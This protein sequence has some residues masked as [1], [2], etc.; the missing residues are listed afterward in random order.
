ML[1]FFKALLY[2]RLAL[3]PALRSSLLPVPTTTTAHYCSHCCN[4]YLLYS[5]S[6]LYY[7]YNLL[8]SKKFLPLTAHMKR[9]SLATSTATAPTAK[10]SSAPPSP[11]P[12]SSLE[13]CFYGILKAKECCKSALY[14]SSQQ[15]ALF[16][17]MTFT[18]SHI[19]V[20]LIVLAERFICK[21]RGAHFP[22]YQS[23]ITIF[24][25]LLVVKPSETTFY[26]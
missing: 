6:L 17:S 13:L 2:S 21:N 10:P 20:F 7:Y 3:L 14:S 1:A 11:T 12:P 8:L 25:S 18:F 16:P 26:R 22:E 24:P 4:N 5:L 15:T 23:K 9:E 19:F